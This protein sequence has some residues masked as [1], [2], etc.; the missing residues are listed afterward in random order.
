MPLYGF[1]STTEDKSIG[2]GYAWE[3]EEASKIRVVFKILFRDWSN[4]YVVDMGD[5]THEK[6]VLLTEG[7]QF[8]VRS[9]EDDKDASG[10]NIK[11]ITL[12]SYD[13]NSNLLGWLLTLLCTALFQPI[14]AMRYLW[15]ASKIEKRLILRGYSIVMIALI[16][17]L[18]L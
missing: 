11:L 8:V 6:E 4:Y 1:I 2:Y 9:V 7:T 18:M 12:Q 15:E 10:N 3:N 13:I 16:A 14:E 5:F 17:H